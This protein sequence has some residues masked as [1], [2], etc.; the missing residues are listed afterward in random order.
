[1]DYDEGNRSHTANVVFVVTQ[2][3]DALIK[4]L[5]Y[6]DGL[7]KR[8]HKGIKKEAFRSNHEGNHQQ[9]QPAVVYDAAL[10]KK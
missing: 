5:R 7:L 9:L 10:F 2:M 8:L 1:M 3:T 4:L 6:A